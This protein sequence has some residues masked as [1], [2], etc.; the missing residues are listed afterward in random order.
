MTNDRSTLPFEE[1]EPFRVGV[2]VGDTRRFYHNRPMAMNFANDGQLRWAE[3]VYSA[4]AQFEPQHGFVAVLFSEHNIPEAWA[5]GYE[6]RTSALVPSKTPEDWAAG[7]VGA[8]RAAKSAPGGST[9][10]PEGAA[11]V[12]GATAR[13]WAIADQVGAAGRGDRAKVIAACV[14]EGINPAT[15]ATQ[16]SKY[17]NSKGW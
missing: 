14:A 2:T 4:T 12:R 15:A 1:D 7:R 8:R 13:V 10:A 6:V 16:W 11:P 9:P 17:A 5:A 3:Q